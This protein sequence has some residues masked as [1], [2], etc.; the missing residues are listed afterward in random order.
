MHSVHPTHKY[1]NQEEIV[2]HAVRISKVSLVRATHLILLVLAIHSHRA[3]KQHRS[4]FQCL[5]KIR[6]IEGGNTSWTIH[7]S[8]SAIASR[9]RMAKIATTYSTSP[10][11]IA[12]TT[13]FASG[14]LTQRHRMLSHSHHNKLDKIWGKQIVLP[15]PLSRFAMEIQK[16]RMKHKTQIRW[17]NP[18]HKQLLNCHQIHLYLDKQTQQRKEWIFRQVFLIDNQIQSTH[19]QLRL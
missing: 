11:H 5:H 15:L 7:I 8:P 10:I 4:K 13:F 2:F 9:H 12:K 1:T 19:S 3:H 18:R 16:L 6:W 17:L 14:I